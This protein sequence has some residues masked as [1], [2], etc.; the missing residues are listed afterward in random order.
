MLNP[1]KQ[2]RITWEIDVEAASAEQ[3]VSQVARDY[4]QA[5]HTAT[6]FEA[7]MYSPPWAPNQLV[8]AGKLPVFRSDNPLE[9]LGEVLEE[10]ELT[11]DYDRADVLAHIAHNLASLLPHD[12]VNAAI[13]CAFAD[14]LIC[15]EPSSSQDK[16]D[17]LR[18]MMEGA[19]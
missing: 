19:Q 17:T 6:S 7:K 12:A 9:R 18:R 14:A 10:Y 8:E 15:L 11:S 13:D 5:G 1:I 3:A 16:A 2:F 4:F